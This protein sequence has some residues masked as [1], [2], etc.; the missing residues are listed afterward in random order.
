MAQGGKTLVTLAGHRGSNIRKIKKMISTN[1]FNVLIS[2]DMRGVAFAGAVKNVTAIAE[3]IAKGLSLKQNM[4]AALIVQLT[5]ELINLGVE[6]GANKNTFLG[7][8]YLGDVILSLDQES[9]NSRLGL[10]LGGGQSFKDFLR[11][12]PN[13]NVEGANTIKELYSYLK[14]R[15]GFVIT[16]HLYQIVHESKDPQSLISVF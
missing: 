10:A 8:S 15:K 7:P 9:R 4:R 6:L 13:I 11:E 5:R 12:N 3:G 1:N 16:K 14:E 2:R